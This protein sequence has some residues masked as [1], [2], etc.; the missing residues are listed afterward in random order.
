VAAG[1]PARPLRDR[2]AAAELLHPL[3]LGRV[4]ELARVRQ[5]RIHQELLPVATGEALASGRQDD[6]RRHPA[7]GGPAVGG[8]PLRLAGVGAPHRVD[9]DR[10][11]QRLLRVDGAQEEEVPVQPVEPQSA[12]RLVT[13]EQIGEVDAVDSFAN[14][15]E[16]CAA[17]ERQGG[18]A[19]RWCNSRTEADIVEPRSTCCA[20]APPAWR[21]SIGRQTAGVSGSSARGGRR[22]CGRGR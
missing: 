1:V 3:E 20:N 12:R 15:A 14:S 17:G 5:H 9:R 18:H 6:A 2:G 4:D 7:E 13:V 10:W 21:H 11:S 16:R 19:G 22:A 8:V